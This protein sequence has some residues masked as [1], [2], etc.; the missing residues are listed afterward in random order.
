MAV[1]DL[2]LCVCHT[3]SVVW[4]DKGN[5]RECHLKEE[6]LEDLNWTEIEQQKRPAGLRRLTTRWFLSQAE[7]INRSGTDS[8]AH[9]AFLSVC[10][11]V[12]VCVLV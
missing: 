2:P 1:R 3:T 9:S 12:C 4:R 11:C 5:C 6:E 7:T 10:L 8:A